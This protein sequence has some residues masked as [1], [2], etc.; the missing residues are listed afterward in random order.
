MAI[1]VE[2]PA[3]AG[4]DA[5]PPPLLQRIRTAVAASALL[6]AGFSLAILVEEPRE[7]GVV[8]VSAAAAGVYALGLAALRGASLRGGLAA[9]EGLGVAGFLFSALLRWSRQARVS[10]GAGRGALAAGWR[11]VMIVIALLGLVTLLIPTN[12]HPPRYESQTIGDIRTLISAQASYQQANPAIENGQC[13]S[14][15]QPLQ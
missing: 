11:A 1:S 3:A 2:P 15:C 9:A 13:A 7:Q 5:P 14:P 4:E 8:V 10:M 6:T 12:V